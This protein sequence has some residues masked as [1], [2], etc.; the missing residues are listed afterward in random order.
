MTRTPKRLNP[1]IEL[2]KTRLREFLREPG[3]LFWVFVFPLLMAFGLGIAFRS[4]PAERPR[5]AVVAQ[6][7]NPLS[8]ALLSS[9]RV[10]AEVKDEASALRDLARAKTDVV[11]KF[12]AAG[13]T[14]VFDATQDKG[15]AA[16]LLVDDIVERAAGRTDRVA[17]KEI[18]SSEPGSRYIDF[19]VTWPHRHEPD[20][21]QHVGRWLQL[22]HGA[23]APFV[24]SLRR[25]THAP[26][27]V[28]N[29][30]FL[31]AKP[32]SDSRD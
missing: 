7:P 23:Q 27:A 11:V 30:L 2:I 8:L 17:I 21:H 9:K 10:V 4:K 1:Q 18:T 16:R 12:D 25:H 13:P 28:S 15:P 5:V 29:G 20:G 6:Q 24:A 32:V 3:A 14:Y 26:A 22:G 31:C 19:P